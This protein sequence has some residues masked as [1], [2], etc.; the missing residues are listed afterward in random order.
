MKEKPQP[1]PPSQPQSQ[2]RRNSVDYFVS[3]YGDLIFDLCESVLWNPTYAQLAFRA[4]LK[5]LRSGVRLNSFVKYERSWVLKVTCE[6]LIALVRQQDF[7]ASAQQQIQLDA[8][9]D[10]EHR[11]KNFEF[12]FH[13]LKPEAQ[14]LMLLKDKHQISDLEIASAL[15]T[16]LEALK[17]QRQQSLKTLEEW[18]WNT[19]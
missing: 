7:T 9:E 14:L 5:A 15:G 19:Y 6:K 11:I 4:I 17:V 8:K 13:R 2:P 1:K 10:T 16:P 3:K 18:L 12:Y